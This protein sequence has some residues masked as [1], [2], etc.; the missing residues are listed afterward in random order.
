GEQQKKRE[1][2]TPTGTIEHETR[3][4]RTPL[5]RGQTRGAAARAPLLWQDASLLRAARA[6]RR[7][8]AAGSPPGTELM[9]HPRRLRRTLLALAE[10]ALAETAVWTAE[11]SARYGALGDRLRLGAV[12]DS[13]LDRAGR[14]PGAPGGGPSDRVSLGILARDSAVARMRVT[15]DDP[16]IARL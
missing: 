3:S 12:L 16:L 14:A 15:W 10:A 5:E 2:S 4:V 1:G 13:A 8:G 9:R 6:V 7:P 11:E